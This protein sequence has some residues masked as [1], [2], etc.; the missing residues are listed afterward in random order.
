ML[1]PSHWAGYGLVLMAPQGGGKTHLAHCFAKEHHALWLTPQM[2]ADTE[3]SQLLGGRTYAVMDGLE[4]FSPE[5]M[6]YALQAAQLQP[7]TKLLLTTRHAPQA[8]KDITSRLESLPKAIFTA[9]DDALL[10]AILCKQLG[11]AQL[12]L[13]PSTL[14]F[15]LPRLE[16]SFPAIQSCVAWLETLAEGD[17]KRLTIPAIKA[18]TQPH[19]PQWLEININ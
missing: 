11:D 5:Q 12:Q 8:P 14:A 6:L 9:P 2:L 19:S 13:P 4:H 17:A 15:L 18:A 16:R 1:N 10:E 3:P 7:N